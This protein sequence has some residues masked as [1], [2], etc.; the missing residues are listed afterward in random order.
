MG[1]VKGSLLTSSQS[2]AQD[3]PI[4]HHQFASAATLL[5]SSL[6]S[7][8]L[9]FNPLQPKRK[10]PRP[11]QTNGLEHIQPRSR[12]EQKKAHCIALSPSCPSWLRGSILF[13]PGTNNQPRTHLTTTPANGLPAIPRQAVIRIAQSL[14]FLHR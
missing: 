7:V 12:E 11:E 1:Q 4:V 3:N 6:F 13:G 5:L 14:C 10:G 8:P 2:Q 9:C